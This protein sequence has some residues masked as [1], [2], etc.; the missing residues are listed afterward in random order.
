MRIIAYSA[1]SGKALCRDYGADEIQYRKLI[2]HWAHDC[3]LSASTMLDLFSLPA[4]ITSGAKHPEQREEREAAKQGAVKSED[5][6]ALG[7]GQARRRMRQH[8]CQGERQNGCQNGCKTSWQDAPDAEE[9]M[10]RSSHACTP[11][12]LKQRGDAGLPAGVFPLLLGPLPAG[13][14]RASAGTG[15]ASLPAQRKTCYQLAL[16][17]SCFNAPAALPAGS[18][19]GACSTCPKETCHALPELR[20]SDYKAER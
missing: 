12:R 10:C 20:T 11:L 13:K 16:P 9:A 17:R 14:A 2:P 6:L 7:G 4:K 1:V 5:G 15:C 18:P 3:G 19:A 8:N